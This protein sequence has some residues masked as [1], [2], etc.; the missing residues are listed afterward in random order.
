MVI[1]SAGFGETGPAGRALEQEILGRVRSA[2][3][4]VIGPNCMGIAY[5]CACY[6]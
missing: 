5:W 6:Q 1:I 3:I 2:G 4:R